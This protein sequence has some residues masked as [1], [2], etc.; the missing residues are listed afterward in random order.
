[1]KKLV[2]IIGKEEF[3]KLSEETQNK[4]SGKEFIENDGTYIP[5]AKFDSLNE[6]KKNL[7]SQLKETNDKINELSKVDT[8][9]LQ[10]KFDDF[11]KQHEIDVENLNKEIKERDDKMASMEYEYK[12]K[13][14]IKNE[15]FSSKSSKKA[16]YEDLL[17]KKL[18]FDNEGNLTGYDD[19]KKTYEENDP[20]A[21]LKE[22]SNDGRYANTGENHDSK[23][24]DEDAY[25]NKIMG[26]K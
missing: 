18:E 11:K 13:D 22:E 12:L 21:F 9:E 16:Y 20:Q 23:D 7:E 14:F 8:S 10:S 4:L 2:D 19:Y 6:T 5:K 17:S 24:F 15:K 3:E 26:I 25:I 1:M